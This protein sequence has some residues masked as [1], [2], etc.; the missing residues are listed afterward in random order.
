MK[1]KL[2]ALILS[3]ILVI[4]LAG[5]GNITTKLNRLSINMNKD[6]VKSIFGSIFIAKASKVDKDGNILDL[7]ECFDEKSKSTYQIFF[8]NDRVS[9]WGRK[10][11]LK[12]FPDLYCPTDK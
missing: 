2:T 6:E 9:Q 11:D 5:C 3:A 4:S 1:Q 8:L 7:W 10:E 12:A